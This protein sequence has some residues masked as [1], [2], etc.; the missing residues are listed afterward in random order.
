ME[1]GVTMKKAIMHWNIPLSSLFDHL[2]G[3]TNWCKKNSFQGV[4]M[5]EK[6]V[7]IVV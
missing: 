4:L 3:K 2:N 7:V 1:R 6:D 5:E